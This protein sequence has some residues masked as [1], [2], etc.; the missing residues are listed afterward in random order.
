MSVASL[1]FHALGSR[2]DIELIATVLRP[3]GFVVARIY[4]HFAAERGGL[5]PRGIEN[6]N[7]DEIVARGIGATGLPRAMLY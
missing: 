7:A 5:D 4:R 6:T 3:R 1:T 2:D